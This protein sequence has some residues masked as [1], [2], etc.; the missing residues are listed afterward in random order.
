MSYLV[1]GM[2]IA[3]KRERDCFCAVKLESSQKEKETEDN[4]VK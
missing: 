1:F 3:T 4:D 2:F